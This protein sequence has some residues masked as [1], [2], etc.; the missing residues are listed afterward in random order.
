MRV[1]LEVKNEALCHFQSSWMQKTAEFRYSEMPKQDSALV[2]GV[3]Y[4][5]SK[6]KPQAEAWGEVSR[7]A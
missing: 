5:S 6:E 1:P 7:F 3:I 2:T 4:D